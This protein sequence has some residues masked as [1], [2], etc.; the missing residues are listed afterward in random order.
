MK[1]LF[2]VLMTCLF[3]M[4]MQAQS[5]IGTWKTAMI[6]D[7][8]KM[9]FYFIF[10]KSTLTMKG[11]VNS[12]DPEVGE[13]V[14]SVNVPCTYTRKGDKVNVKTNPNK[15]KINIDKMK[16]SP[17][18]E[19]MVKDNPGM[20]KMIENMMKQAMENSKGE[21]VNGFPSG[22]DLT[23]VTLTNTNLSLRDETGEMIDFTRV[24]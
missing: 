7:G 3:A 5:L 1:K 11:V 15:A 23:I 19:S 22:G 2:F 24:K 8:Q 21:I 13:I 10:A 14:I 18:M 6:E 20:K 4:S 16:F 17:E 12:N 9:D